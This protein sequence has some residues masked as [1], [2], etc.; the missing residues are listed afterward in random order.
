MKAEKFFLF[1]IAI[2]CIG[3]AASASAEDFVSGSTGADGPFNPTSNLELQLPPDGVFNFTTVN[4]PAGVTVKFGKNANNT[5][6]Y[7]LASGDVTI[8]GTLSASGTYASE[9]TP[10]QGGPG[11]FDGGYGAMPMGRGGSGLGYGNGNPGTY[12]YSEYYKTYVAWGGSGGGYGSAGGNNSYWDYYSHWPDYQIGRQVGGSSYGDAKLI[13]LIGGS[14][15]GGGGGHTTGRGGAGGG[16][17]GAILIASSGN[18]TVNGTITASGGSG[19]NGGYQ[20]GCGGGGS[21]GAIRLI[22]NGIS[23]GGTIS[24]NAGIG[25]TSCQNAPYK[26][27]AGDGGSGR[28]RLESYN[29]NLGKNTSPTYSFAYPGLVFLSKMPSL[30]ITSVGGTAVPVNPTGSYSAPDITLPVGTANPIPVELAASDIPLGTTIIVS[31]APQYG[32]SPSAVNSSPLSG[33]IEASTATA[34]VTLTNQYPCMIT[35][36]ASFTVQ[37]AMYYEGEKI[38]KATVASTM[39]KGSEVIYITESGKEIPAE[40]LLAS[41]SL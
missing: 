4:I 21:G 28:I 33:A 15:G 12:G 23:G 24:A 32:T 18:I 39:G 37:V 34:N 8:S 11:G 5:P 2:V 3:I 29:L 40:K 1:I 14:G 22:A 20:A 41:L 19:G 27:K 9:W 6:A 17:G 25:G 36:K 31:V 7:I 30:K 10:G 13:P 26:G 35:A 38:E 16:G